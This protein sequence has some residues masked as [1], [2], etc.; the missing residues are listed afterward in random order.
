MLAGCGFSDSSNYA[1]G[2]FLDAQ[3]HSVSGRAEASLGATT[4]SVEYLPPEGYPALPGMSPTLA[5]GT[6]GADSVRAVFGFDLRESAGWG[7]LAFLQRHPI[8]AITFSVGDTAWK[9][10]VRLRLVRSDSATLPALFMGI[11]PSQLTQTRILWDTVV[12]LAADSVGMYNIRID[13]ALSESIRVSLTQERGWLAVLLDPLAASGSYTKTMT[14]I[15]A[16]PVLDRDTLP[17]TLGGWGGVLATRNVYNRAASSSSDAIGWWA[18]TGRRARFE[19]DGD[20]IRASLHRQVPANDISPETDNSYHVLQ[21]RANLGIKSWAASANASKR[22]LLT[23]KVID[24]EDS[25]HLVL[26]TPARMPSSVLST[27]ESGVDGD[28]EVKC[29]ELVPSK[30]A[31]CSVVIAGTAQFNY[32][33]LASVNLNFLAFNQDHFWLRTDVA[34]QAEFEVLNNLR[35]SVRSENSDHGGSHLWVK[36]IRIYSKHASDSQND[37]VG[38]RSKAT[39]VDGANTIELEMRSALTQVIV[40]KKRKVV[41]DLVPVGGSA[42]GLDLWTAQMAT[43]TKLIDSVHVLLRPRDGRNF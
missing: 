26:G 23:S 12:Q 15:G 33:R 25:A 4:R 30:L 24:R 40:Q 38:V 5:I 39:L 9:P 27:E 21:A 6:V 17:I 31:D 20:A 3:G 28:I 36:W 29:T 13:S 18:G 11:E 42:Y 2:A 35:V 8:R 32:T 34:D 1:G 16:Q 37:S 10:A 41:L 43:G 7:D 14:N 22:M 19:L